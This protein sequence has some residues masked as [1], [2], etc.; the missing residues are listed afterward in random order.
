MDRT[1]TIAKRELTS[2]FYSPVAYV[3]LAL[4]ALGTGL[5]FLGLEF[6]PGEEATL[7]TTFNY[8]VGFLVFLVPAISMR[9]LSE[10]YRAGSIET[11]M[12]SPVSDG[13]VVVGKWLGAMGFYLALL[14]PMLVF[15]GL[16]E[17][18]GRPD[19][20]PIAAGFLGLLLV[21]GLY[22]A[23]GAFASSVTESQI[24]AFL[25]TV[26]IIAV[27]TFLLSSLPYA[28]FVSPAWRSGL[29]YAGVYRH[30]QEFGKGV[31]QLGGLVYFI[32]GIGF[33]LFLATLML[34]SRRWR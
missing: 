13:Q 25:L 27:F 21:G 16:L 22:L 4:F 12:T 9:L 32:S 26:F 24:I 1:L 8:V 31:V 18:F 10:E 33:F 19:Y 34:E 29:F 30:F 3:V 23:I 11:L 5:I 14:C 2:L 15:T 20:G 17:V 6:A 7:R 28:Q